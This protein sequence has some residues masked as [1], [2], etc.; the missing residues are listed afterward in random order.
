MLDTL[1][2]WAAWLWNWIT[3]ITGSVVGFLYVAF[4][5]ISAIGAQAGSSGWAAAGKALGGIGDAHF[6]PPLAVPRK[7]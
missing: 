3:V 2:S 7:P 1:K 4:D 6:D 5:L